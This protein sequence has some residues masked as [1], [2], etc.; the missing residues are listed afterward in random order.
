ML[1]RKSPSP[2]RRS[3]T[4][5]GCHDPEE[6]HTSKFTH[7]KQVVNGKSLIQYNSGKHVVSLMM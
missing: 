2:S 1:A 7:L 6:K 5:D 4:D 3:Y